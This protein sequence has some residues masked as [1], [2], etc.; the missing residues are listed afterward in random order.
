MLEGTTINW[1]G[2][3]VANDEDAEAGVT[4]DPV[5]PG[6]TAS[7]ALIATNLGPAARLSQGSPPS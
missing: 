6:Q 3:K 2:L 7:Y 5:P 1:D 4:Q